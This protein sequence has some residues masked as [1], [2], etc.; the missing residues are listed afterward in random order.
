[1]PP[2]QSPQTVK[3]KVAPKNPKSIQISSKATRN[4][5]SSLISSTSENFIERKQSTT[6]APP[7]PIN[8][9]EPIID[10]D[11]DDD[12]D[13]TTEIFRMDTKQKKGRTMMTDER[14]YNL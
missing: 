3:G 5:R 7:P 4:G 6:P 8:A 10:F 14:D 9:D 11:S 13:L 1:M 12:F 2:P